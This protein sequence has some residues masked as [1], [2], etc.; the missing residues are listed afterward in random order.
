MRY[1]SYA[2]KVSTWRTSTIRDPP[3]PWYYFKYRGWRV[4][5][6]EYVKGAPPRSP[7]QP[8]EFPTNEIR[9]FN[10]RNEKGCSTGLT[11]VIWLYCFPITIPPSIDIT[12]TSGSRETILRF[13]RAR[14]WQLIW[15]CCSID[16]RPTW[17]IKKRRYIFF[18]FFSSCTRFERIVGENKIYQVLK[19]CHRRRGCR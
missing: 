12:S 16:F 6:S 18:S 10:D 11:R 1:I 3:P 9:C 2:R 15:I 5:L 14:P 4:V 8:H 13:S 7:S 17:L 19:V